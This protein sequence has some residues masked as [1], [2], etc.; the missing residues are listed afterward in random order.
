MDR[1]RAAHAG[2]FR[3]EIRIGE[4]APTCNV[5]LGLA[6]GAGAGLDV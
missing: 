2:V 3:F 1:T 4:T 5:P 6:I